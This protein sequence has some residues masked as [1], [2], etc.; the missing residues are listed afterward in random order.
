MNSKFDRFR[1]VV[2]SGAG[3]DR[4]PARGNLDAQFDDAL[5]FGMRQRRGFAGGANRHQTT[6]SS[7]DHALDMARKA[8][9]IHRAI[10][11]ETG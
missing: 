7:L 9:L 3:D 2:R 4:N 6:A 10:L 11:G 8:I 1:R 5:V